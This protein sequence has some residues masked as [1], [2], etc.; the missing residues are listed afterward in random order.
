MPLLDRQNLEE[1]FNINDE[2]PVEPEIVDDHD[3]FEAE[4]ER[5]NDPRTIIADNIERANEILDKVQEEI[6]RG[7]FTARLVEVAGNLI[8]SVTAASKELISDENYRRYL[9]LRDKLVKLKK[10][11]VEWKVSG[12]SNKITNQNLILANREDIL[13]IMGKKDELPAPEESE[14][15]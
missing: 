14:K 6:Q 10:V 12:K 8:N 1:E 15:N 5:E 3:E 4:W 11:E 7:N 9:H 13:K 2:Q